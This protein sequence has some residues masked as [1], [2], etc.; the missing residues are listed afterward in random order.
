MSRKEL[1]E[2]HDA[3]ALGRRKQMEIGGDEDE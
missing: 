1:N 2:L 3:Q